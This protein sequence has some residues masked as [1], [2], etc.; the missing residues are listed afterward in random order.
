VNTAAGWFAVAFGLQA[1][2]LGFAAAASPAA[3]PA[4]GGRGSGLALAAVAAGGYP[5]ATVFL[6]GSG[7]QAE[8]ALAFPD[9]TA[10]LTVGLLLAL[11]LRARA[12]LL[13]IPL[14]AVLVGAIT[15][16]LLWAG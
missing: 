12:A 7:S 6:R 5:L 11:P 8:V 2:A 4:A 9:P 13:A 10:L 3:L 14:L 16:W 1:V 15:A